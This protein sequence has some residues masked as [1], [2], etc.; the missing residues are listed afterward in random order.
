ML[1]SSLL[2]PF[3]L[4]RGRGYSPTQTGELVVTMQLC[5]IGGSFVGGGL[6]ARSGGRGLGV[7]SMAAVAGGL[8]ALGQLGTELPFIWLFPF[9][10]VLGAAQS[11]FTAVN[12]TTVINQTVNILGLGAALF[13]ILLRLDL[14]LTLI[15][16]PALVLV[17]I[18]ALVYSPLSR[19]R[20]RRIGR[21]TRS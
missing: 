18:L 10:A 2:L 21:A 5:S 19:E 1:A 13:F 11:S 9:V 17:I 14:R 6:Y 16:L 12:N 15:S 3:L 7:G 4:E 8:L 20:S